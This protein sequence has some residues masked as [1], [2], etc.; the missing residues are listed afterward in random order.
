MVMSE[1]SGFCECGCGQKTSIARWDIRKR[2]VVGGKPRRFVSNH[3]P[4]GSKSPRWRG[5]KTIMAGYVRVFFPEHPCASGN[6]VRE[7]TLI[8]ERALGRHLRAPEQVHHVNRITTDNRPRNLV[9]CPDNMYHKLLERRGHAFDNCGHA[10][11]R[12]CSFCHQYDDPKNLRVGCRTVC[13]RECKRLDETKR[14]QARKAA[15]V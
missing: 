10:N 12:R 7:H 2:G 13:H 1:A 3:K 4:K 8:A 5:G 11:W 6:Y 9:V 15:K 14:R